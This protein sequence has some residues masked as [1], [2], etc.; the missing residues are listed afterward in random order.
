[1]SLCPP[2]QFP[3]SSCDVVDEDEDSWDFQ[4]LPPLDDLAPLPLALPDLDLPDEWL[5]QLPV[6]CEVVDEDEGSLSLCPPSHFPMSCEVVDEDEDEGS[7]CPPSQFPLSSCDVVDED[8]D[9]WGFQRLP[10]LD[11]LV[12]LPLA[13]P[14]FDLPDEWPSQLPVSCEVV[15]ED[16]GSLCPPSQFPLSSCEVVD[17]NVLDLLD[18]EPHVDVGGCP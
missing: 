13:L 9:P 6:S 18:L 12:P 4:R 10:P 15:E 3:L 7:L 11:D 1:V 5:P 2:S 14:D 8:E 17:N 16:E